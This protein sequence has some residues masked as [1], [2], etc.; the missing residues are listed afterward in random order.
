MESGSAAN[1]EN[2]PG[3]DANEEEAEAEEQP[4]MDTV[5]DGGLN[6]K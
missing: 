4:D 2:S 3:D 6:Q 5:C 1:L